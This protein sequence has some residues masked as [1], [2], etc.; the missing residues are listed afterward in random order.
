MNHANNDWNIA[1]PDLTA[2]T[3]ESVLPVVI[4]TST[5][6]IPLDKV[7]YV[8]YPDTLTQLPLTSAPVEGL[9]RFNN[10]PLL[11]IS[12]AQA[13]NLQPQ[14]G[15]GRIVVMCVPKGEI[16]LH[17]DEVL[18]F[19]SIPKNVP[20]HNLQRHLNDLK[21]PPPLANT[22]TLLELNK[23]L[24]WLE[25]PF[26][27]F[28][29]PIPQIA[30]QSPHRANTVGHILLVSTGERVVALLADTVDRIEEIDT[31]LNYRHPDSAADL[32]VKI[33]DYLLP[34]RSLAKILGG[35]CNNERYALVVHGVE[36]SCAL[37]VE[38]VLR[39]ER[40]TSLHSVLSPSGVETLWYIDDDGKVTEMID[41]KEF[42]G[43]NSPHSPIARTAPK[44]PR[45]SPTQI[46][47]NLSTEGIRITFGSTV[48]ILP[49]N[50][51]KRTIGN[52]DEIINEHRELNADMVPVIDGVMMFE[53][54]QKQ[55]E[56]CNILLSLCQ[57]KQAVLA[58]D[59]AA[60]QPSLSIGNWLPLTVLPPPTASLF[61]A[62]SYDESE[63]RWILR[64]ANDWEVFFSSWITKRAIVGSMLG[65]IEPS[66]LEQASQ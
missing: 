5:F 48:C 13:L 59:R 12:V 7:R 37:L 47:A 53:N 27:D 50:L 55:S 16:A 35:K 29:A 51:V 3:T 44:I 56:H 34:A 31:K 23:V 4:G 46:S 25:M 49:L 30:Q 20:T 43:I 11:Q 28:H 42:F 61:D 52:V 21:E 9:M 58:A 17:V 45:N 1:L 19:I 60:L 6:G 64:I 33:D 24:P 2:A 22:M 63:G 65:W 10:R 54:H 38:H 14:N 40:V 32:L 15:A 41:I 26:T 18:G 39:L 36:N 62:A 8:D 57:D 66:S